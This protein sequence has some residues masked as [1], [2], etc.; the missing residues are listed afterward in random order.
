MQYD[1]NATCSRLVN[2]LRPQTDIAH[3]LDKAAIRELALA[4]RFWQ[5]VLSKNA[6]FA[7]GI[8]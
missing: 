3:S 1:Q 6:S 2:A 7:L 8:V 5:K 4:E